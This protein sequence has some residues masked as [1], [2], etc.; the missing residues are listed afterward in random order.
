MELDNKLNKGLGKREAVIED[1]P[2]SWADLGGSMLELVKEIG[3]KMVNYL[4]DAFLIF[5]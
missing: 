1:G 3:K 4:K 5:Y 2:Q